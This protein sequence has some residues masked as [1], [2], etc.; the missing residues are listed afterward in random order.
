MK[1][2]Q[3]GITHIKA[4]EGDR[5]TGYLDSTGLPTIG[6]GHTGYV[7]TQAVYPGMKISQDTST[8][9]LLSDLETVEKALAQQVTVPLNQNQYDALCSLVFNIGVG[10][11]G[12]STLLRRLNSGDYDG[13]SEAFL[14]WKR[15]GHSE[16]ILLPRRKRERELF[17]S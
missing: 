10:A 13:A 3:A 17:L 11:F 12:K 15:A 6:V 2:S 5:L 16:D 1:I 7:G 9:L 4:E 8:T 14:M